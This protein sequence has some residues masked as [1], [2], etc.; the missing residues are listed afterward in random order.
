MADLFDYLDEDNSNPKDELKEIKNKK[1]EQDDSWS[2][3]E[4]RE[5]SLWVEK[6]RPK[7]LEDYVGNE[8]MKKK[9]QEFIN[10]KDIPHLLLHDSTPGT[11]KTTAAKMISSLI[12]GD[13][14]Y[15]NASDKG[16]VDFIRDEIQPFCQNMSFTGGLKIVI[17]DECDYMS[18]NGQAALRNMM[19]TYSKNV[20]FILTCNYFEKLIDPLKSRCQKFSIVPPTKSEI[21]KRMIYILTEE[22]I[23]YDINDV[24]KIIDDNF[25]DIRSIIN[26]IQ[27]QI[28]ED[29]QLVLSKIK[30]EAKDYQ[31]QIISQLTKKDFGKS[32]LEIRQILANS[33]L[34]H[35]DGI[36]KFLYDNLDKFAKGHM[37]NV[38]IIISKYQF[39]SSFVP[40][41]EIPVMSMFSEIINE[42]S[43]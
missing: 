32:W 36:Y 26:S 10:K 19:E 17:L 35:F 9:F 39:E 1:Y 21:E 14:K 20:R 18:A 13:I 23:S 28:N 29:N 16:G 6:Y 7:N 5:N 8:E 12:E 24:K 22:K 15:V 37:A 4:G 41:K 2:L 38:T 31:D 40:D 43:N 25:P 33:K 11:G 42:L 34:K 3:G 27:Q 30:S